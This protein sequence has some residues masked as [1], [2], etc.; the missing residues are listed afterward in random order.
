VLPEVGRRPR[1]AVLRQIGRAG[2]QDPQIV[3]ELARDHRRR[4]LGRRAHGHVDPLLDQI[5]DVVRHVEE[6]THFRILALK[7]EH[8]RQ[9]PRMTEHHRRGD[10]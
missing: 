3:V 7:R 5:D 4:R 6:H 8:H 2:A 1:R 9:D 10:A